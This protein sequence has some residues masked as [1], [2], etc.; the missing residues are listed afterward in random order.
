M[1]AFTKA[2]LF[3]SAVLLAAAVASTGSA[4]VA[5]KPKASAATTRLVPRQ[6][7]P[8]KVHRWRP[9]MQVD[10]ENW[11]GYAVTGS[12]F[13]QVLGSWT[14]PSVNCAE[15][16]ATR[17]SNVYASFWVGIDGYTSNTV[18]Q[19]GTDSDCDYTK[20]GSDATYYAWYEFY[21]SFSYE[22]PSVP[23]SP[24]DEMSAEVNYSGTEFTVT[25]TDKTTGKSF[26]TTKSVKGAKRSS[27][28]WIVEAPC[29][30][31]GGSYLPLSDFGTVG[32]GQ[33]YNTTPHISGTNYATDSATSGQIS[34]F[35]P[36]VYTLC[37]ET[38]SS[39]C[40]SQINMVTS[41]GAAEDTSSNLSSDG[42]SFQVTWDTE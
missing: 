26:S 31:R 36:P 12:S 11:S 32:L 28:E 19:I 8:I 10:S 20:Q 9:D 21:P 35:G 34:F 30:G 29:C 7:G 3:G 38:N 42:T 37:T 27:A 18:E 16:P 15:T 33:D 14:V 6:H 39:N 24:G 2:A 41:S 5:G 22:I 17:S 23:V 40:L 4:Q 25:I 1:R 13:T